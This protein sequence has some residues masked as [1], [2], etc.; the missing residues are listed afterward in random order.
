MS[1]AFA[2]RRAAT[3]AVLAIAAAFTAAN[4]N[5][6]PE[7]ITF[8][9]RKP[10]AVPALRDLVIKQE[11]MVPVL[12]G[13]T[14]ASETEFDQTTI[15]MN[16]QTRNGVQWEKTSDGSV[17]IMKRYSQIELYDNTKF[18]GR[19]LMTI[20]GKDPK[21][22]A[23][24]GVLANSSLKDGQ[25][26]M[27]RA[28]VYAPTNASANDPIN[29]PTRYVEYWIGHPKTKKGSLLAINF[30]GRLIP[31]FAKSIPTPQEKPVQYGAIYT[32]VGE[33]LLKGA[34]VA[35]AGPITSTLALN[36]N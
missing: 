20:A 17:C 25:N 16:P 3:P 4:A 31:H 26:P 8:G 15:M 18:E 13:F 24:N 33:D 12:S 9:C 11:G 7:D 29:V 36:K 1:L 28:T 27:M 6:A 19:A 14:A 32:P 10:E 34:R 21:Q 30:E 22:I 2:L 5:A 23:V 35:D